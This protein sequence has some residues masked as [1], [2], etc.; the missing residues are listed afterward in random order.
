M[1]FVLDKLVVEHIFSCCF[2]FPC[3]FQVHNRLLVGVGTVGPIVS[4]IPSRLTLISFYEMKIKNSVYQL[5]LNGT[6]LTPGVI[7]VNAVLN[8]WLPL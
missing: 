4:G 6:R 1:S 3:H 8:I 5:D 7:F 2:G